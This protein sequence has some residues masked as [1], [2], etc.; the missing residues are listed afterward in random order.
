MLWICSECRDGTD[1]VISEELR[2]K[3]CPL[4][5]VFA[6]VIFKRLDVD[7]EVLIQELRS[8]G[9]LVFPAKTFDKLKVDLDFHLTFLNDIGV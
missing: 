5:D 1:C 4:G 9:Y 3:N 7:D 2:P 8:R 6:D